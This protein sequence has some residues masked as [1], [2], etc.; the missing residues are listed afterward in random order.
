MQQ[1]MATGSRTITAEQLHS[2]PDDGK[3][4]ELARGV[5][6]VVSPSGWEHSAI[7][8]RLARL[9]AAWTD[10]RGLGIVTGADGGYVLRRNPD[11]LYAPDV[12]FVRAARVPQGAARKVFFD[13]APDLAAEI[14]SPTD[15]WTGVMQKV[16]DYLA[17]GAGMVLVVDPERQRVHVFAPGVALAVLQEDDTLEGADVVPGWRLPLRELFTLASPG[18]GD[19]AG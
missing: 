10:A 5:V 3:R 19:S 1:G 15:T 7:G 12:G 14:L 17:A 8:L 13:G 6:R 18:V 9:L 4:R 11:T 16:D 2:L